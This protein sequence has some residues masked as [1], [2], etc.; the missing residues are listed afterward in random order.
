ME[1]RLVFSL[2]PKR[3]NPEKDYEEAVAIMMGLGE[4]FPDI[5][6][7]DGGDAKFHVASDGY[8]FAFTVGG[9]SEQRLRGFNNSLIKKYELAGFMNNPSTLKA[10]SNPG[11]NSSSNATESKSDCFIA[12]AVFEGPNHPEVDLLRMYRDLHLRNFMI[13]KMFI[14]AY[15]FIGPACAKVISKVETLKRVVKQLILVLVIPFVKRK[16][17]R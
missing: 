14:K 5:Y 8:V 2:I 11:K 7:V 6:P 1:A 12:T 4:N 3:S 17:D 15:Y 13:G 9:P 16:I 10:E